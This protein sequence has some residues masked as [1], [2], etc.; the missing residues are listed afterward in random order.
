MSRSINHIAA[1]HPSPWAFCLV[2]SSMRFVN[3]DVVPD[4]SLAAEAGENHIVEPGGSSGEDGLNRC[5]DREVIEDYFPLLMVPADQPFVQQGA[6]LERPRAETTAG[7]ERKS[8][9]SNSIARIYSPAVYRLTP[10]TL[11]I[12]TLLSVGS[13]HAS[14]SFS[15]N[16]MLAYCL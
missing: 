1:K 13:M 12:H 3:M 14:T 15:I 10:R 7:K 6:D 16:V 11:H 4:N 5:D 8:C 9:I 2:T